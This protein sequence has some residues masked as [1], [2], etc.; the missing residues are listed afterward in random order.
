VEE[1]FVK[2]H[3]PQWELHSNVQCLLLIWLVSHVPVGL[4]MS[5]H[6]LIAVVVSAQL[7]RRLQLN[8]TT[9]CVM[10]VLDSTVL[11]ARGVTQ[12][13]HRNAG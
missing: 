11:T 9:N 8:T 6:I 10:F 13:I 4:A 3:Q 5:L 7:D 12:L 1:D 2:H